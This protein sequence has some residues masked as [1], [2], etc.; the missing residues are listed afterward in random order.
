MRDN[1]SRITLVWALV[2]AC[3]IAQGCSGDSSDP[4]GGAGS[5]GAGGS[6]SVTDGGD[7]SVGNVGCLK[8]EMLPVACP[9]PPVTYAK[10]QPFI[11]ANCAGLCHNGSTPDPEHPGEFLWGLTT[12]GHVT[13]WLRGIRDSVGNCLMPPADAG[14]PM[15]IE[16][17]IA[18]LEYVRCNLP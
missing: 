17:R 5:G 15:T 4:D 18:I 12:E 9:T 2:S 6:G 3:W 13:D 10:V 7:G 8:M 11:Q 16:A 1:V 14:V